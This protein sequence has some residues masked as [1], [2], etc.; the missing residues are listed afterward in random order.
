MEPAQEQPVKKRRVQMPKIQLQESH[1]KESPADLAAKQEGV[2]SKSRH[3]N[4]IQS[5]S[6]V[7]TIP[8]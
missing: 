6:S 5:Y 3:D 4:S 7:S 2:G 1:A 8:V